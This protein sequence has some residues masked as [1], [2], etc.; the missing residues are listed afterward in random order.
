[1]SHGCA[2]SVL[3]NSAHRATLSHHLGL[4][5]PLAHLSADIVERL[6]VAPGRWTCSQ[7]GDAH[8]LDGGIVAEVVGYLIEA[9]KIEP[10]DVSTLDGQRTAALTLTERRRR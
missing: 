2:G 5:M 4:P 6:T 1:M 7:I 10:A 8:G 3:R 9:G